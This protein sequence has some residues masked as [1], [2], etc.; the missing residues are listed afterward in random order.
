M[1]VETLSYYNSMD[2][3]MVSWNKTRFIKFVL[4]YYILFCLSGYGKIFWTINLV[5]NFFCAVEV[6]FT[7][8]F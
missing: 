7:V 5:L 3:A 8:L 4:M 6:F 2:L 1:A